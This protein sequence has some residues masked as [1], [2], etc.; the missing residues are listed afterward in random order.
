MYRCVAYTEPHKITR[1]AW[2]A[3][4]HAAVATA[5]ARHDNDSETKRKKC[6]FTST[7]VCQ[8]VLAMAW[9]QHLMLEALA[10]IS[11]ALAVIR[12]RGT[13]LL[14]RVTAWLR[15][16]CVSVGACACVCAEMVVLSCCRR[17]SKMVKMTSTVA[18]RGKSRGTPAP[19]S[20]VGGGG[21]SDVRGRARS[22]GAQGEGA[23]HSLLNW[24]VIFAIKNS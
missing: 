16:D 4:G 10:C 19:S 1:A 20:V 22:S 8:L 11:V 17:A 7:C 21:G 6:A 18:P 24:I 13:R 14:R 9:L 12:P 3:Y 5:A 2:H 23:W 15:C